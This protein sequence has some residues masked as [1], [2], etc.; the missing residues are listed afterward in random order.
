M[1][2][3]D[4]PDFCRLTIQVCQLVV[5]DRGGVDGLLAKP[6]TRVHRKAVFWRAAL[7]TKNSHAHRLLHQNRLVAMLPNPRTGHAA[8]PMMAALLNYRHDRPR[9]A[10]VR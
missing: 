6:D 9:R 1:H 4:Q 5:F 8:D 10:R 2:G 3:V 7:L